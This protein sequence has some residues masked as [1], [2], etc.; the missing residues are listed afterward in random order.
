MKRAH[1]RVHLLVWM[2][3]FPLIGVLGVLFWMH[4]PTDT[5]KLAP[6]QLESLPADIT[7]QGA[8]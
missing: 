5:I 6:E 4:Q 2:V 7:T 8:V 3:L 1:R